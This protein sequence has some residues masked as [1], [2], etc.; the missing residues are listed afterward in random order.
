MTK[1]KATQQLALQHA[2][3]NLIVCLQG[4]TKYASMAGE[5]IMDDTLRATALEVAMRYL[6]IPYR[7]GGD[8][9][10]AGYD[11]SGF[12][13]EVLKSVGLIARR[14]DF[15]AQGLWELF[16][17]QNH[18]VDEPTSGCLVFWSKLPN[19]PAC[20]VEIC[21]DTFLAIG[22]SGGGSKTKTTQDAINQNAY[23]K[24]RPI[25]SRQGIKGYMDPFK[26]RKGVTT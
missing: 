13:I 12:V 8:D 18:K 15:T 19:T 20:H 25:G 7:W 24:I 1:L 11:C 14:K 17:A 2:F 26:E 16:E 22:A 23:I 5:A 10:M 21:L 6:G 9:P 3:N 4:V